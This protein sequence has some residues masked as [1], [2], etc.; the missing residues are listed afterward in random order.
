MIRSMMVTT[1]QSPPPV[2]PK[3]LSSL[4]PDL[5]HPA[6]WSLIERSLAE[7]LTP[8][9]DLASLGADITNGDITS[10]AILG[11]STILG[12]QITA[13]SPGVVAGLPVAQAVFE[14]VAAHTSPVISAGVSG[15]ISFEPSAADGEKVSRGQVLAR[16]SG[17]GRSILAAERTALD[18]LGRLSGIATLTRR[19]VEAVAGTK[20]VILDTRKTAP[21]LRR[22]DKYAVRQGGGANHRMGLY[23]MIL[24]KD[25][26]LDAAGSVT[27]AVRRARRHH[28]GRFLIEVEVKNLA[29]LE[30]ALGLEVDRIMLDNM[31]LATMREAV[32]ITGGRVPLEASGNVN[33][34]TVRA[35][36]ETGVDFISVGALTHSAPV[37]DVSLRLS[38]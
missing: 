15:E 4:P 32:R 5:Q 9:D 22:P 6:V 2:H 12:G 7:D 23:D 16:V 20:A 27:E 18:F 37:L 34:D 31:D 25:N 38:L 10:A 17:P 28:G 8:Q 19:Y 36:A 14:W 13:K 24:I 35:I 11:E 3:G 26:H 21:G 29:E 1:P 33:L 30:E